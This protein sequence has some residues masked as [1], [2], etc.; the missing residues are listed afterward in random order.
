VSRIKIAKD[1]KTEWF[2][3]KKWEPFLFQQ[4]CW[5]LFATG[6]SGLLNAPTGSGKTYALA[7][8][9]LEYIASQKQDGAKGL[10]AIWITPIRALANDLQQA[11]SD[12]ASFI[13]PDA[14]VAVRTGDTSS[15]ER[16]QQK[17]NVPNF[18][19][20]TPES[21]QLMLAQKGSNTL[22]EN[23]GC[24]V[25]DEWHE[26][27]GGKRGVLVELA[28]SRLRS[29]APHFRTWGISATIGNLQEAMEVLLGDGAEKGEMVKSSIEKQIEIVSI[30]PDEMDTFPWAGHLGTKLIHKV[31]PI[32]QQ[33]KTTLLFTNT[34][35]Q[36]EIWYQA[37]LQAMPELAGSMAMH[38]GSINNELRY[39]V[40]QQLHTGELK[41]V[42]CTSSL[43][44]GVDFRPV[45]QV[46]QVGGPKGIARFLQRAGRSGHQPG[47]VSRIYFLPTHAI[48]LMEASAMRKA[49]ALQKME[50]KIPVVRAFDVLCQYLVSLAV[51]DGLNDKQVF[52]EV[53][54]TYCFN[55]ITEEEWDWVLH[56]I[57]QG[58]KSLY[59]YDEF[60][61]VERDADGLYRV[62]NKRIAL[63]HR[64]SIGVIVSDPSI[65]VK[66]M[67]GSRLGSVEEYFISKMKPGD[68]FTF[69]GKSLEIVQFKDLAV[70]VR[71]VNRKGAVASW[72]GGRLPLSNRLSEMLREGMSE[73]QNGT[74]R[75]VE[76][77]AVE[78]V[79][80]FQ[81]HRSVLP[82][83]DELLI[84]KLTSSEGYHVFVYPFEGRNVHEGLSG[85]M[86]YRISRQLPISFSIAFNDYGFE[87]LSDQP[88]P[89][90]DALEE[91]VFSENNLLDDMI[92]SINSME[93]AK[94]KFRDI[95]NIAGLIFTGF[96]GKSMKTKHLQAS[97]SMFFN[98][99]SE[100]EPDNLLVK[101]AYEEVLLDQLEEL[102]LRETLKRIGQQQI[103]LVELSQPSPFAF[104]IMV[105]RLR[106]KM[107]SETV[108]D[109]VKKMQIK[110]MKS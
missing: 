16:Q 103:R 46:I 108:E 68:V 33:A 90:E 93:M 110:L 7:L 80:S 36:T 24:V 63:R 25:V 4:Q 14:I 81:Q 32:I 107:S 64:L 21:L 59:A 22:F 87:L 98:V 74:E 5:K 66:Y 97:S 44:L 55:S 39:W 30:I 27:I 94:R 58:G 10:M 84:E 91:D 51:G 38:H 62:L 75:D 102:R 29:I 52:Q 1:L 78:K 3:H 82:S 67:N 100:Y 71:K 17:R 77:T 105:D 28:L 106:E 40:E 83:K 26:L 34:R 37:L 60:K 53:K 69:A 86:A 49:I 41:V 109:R 99:L 88:I 9:A 61:K 56:F 13:C 76:Y 92:H 2:L 72:Q 96:P 15:K 104:P 50:S 8:P 12:A 19:I 65:E 70:F 57:T 35:A 73:Y 42:V 20:T 43:D 45:E 89:I 31:L 101:Q 47:A 95:A 11:I 85:L 79:L 6:K 48:E 54:S 18:L 23:L